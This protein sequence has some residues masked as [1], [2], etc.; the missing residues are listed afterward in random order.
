MK[1][2]SFSI[3][4]EKVLRGMLTLILRDFGIKIVSVIGQIILVRLVAPEYFGLFAIIAFVVNFAELFSDLGLSQAIVQKKTALSN[5]ELNTIVLLKLILSTLVFFL[6]VSLFPIIKL[7]YRQLTN[8]AFLMLVLLGLSII[9]KAVKRVFLALFDKEINFRSVSKIDIIG[10]IFYFTVAIVLALQKVFIWNF[11]F[12]ILI[13]EIV[14][15]ILVFYYKP[16]K[17]SFLFDLKSVRPLI[18]YGYFLQIGNFIAFVE[19]SIV[20]IVGFR[21][22]SYNLGLLDWSARVVRLT[23]TVFENYGRAAFAGMSQIQDKKEKLSNVCNKSISFLNIFSFLFVLLTLGFSR[24]FVTLAL[25]DKWIP[26]LPSLYYFASSLLFFG[27]S[28]TIAHALLAAGKS[29]DVTIMTGINMIFE[30]MIAFFVMRYVGFYGIA[31][32]VYIGNF[33]QLIAYFILSRKFGLG[34][35]VKSPFFEKLAIFIFSGIIAFILNII[36]PAYS[37]ITFGIK[38]FATTSIYIGLIFLFAKEEVYELLKVTSLLKG[39]TQ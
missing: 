6:L 14:E 18:Q 25:S 8:D 33:T 38:I 2:D 10:V 9:I 30:V 37:F 39:K 28:I 32:A 4:K 23:D 11:I 36:F 26:A 5:V 7:F 16:W 31:I 34:I 12:A 3:L 27:G 13:K 21:L 24:E 29:K 20:P 22:S 1:D 19:N 15:F 17:P 35:K